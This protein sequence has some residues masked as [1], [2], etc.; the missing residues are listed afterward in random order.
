VSLATDLA[1]SIVTSGDADADWYTTVI[2]VLAGNRSNAAIA[3]LNRLYE[4]F[5]PDEVMERS[6]IIEALRDV[7]RERQSQL[8]ETDK[9][10]ELNLPHCL[11]SRPSQPLDFGLR[12]SRARTRLRG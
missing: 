2:R 12:R 11:V 1:E 10:E 7:L 5:R 9:W 4:H 3:T 6:A 8:G